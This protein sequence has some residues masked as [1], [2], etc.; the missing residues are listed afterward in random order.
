MKVKL[1]RISSVPMF[2]FIHIVE[3]LQHYAD[4][5]NIHTICIKSQGPSPQV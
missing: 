2:S 1:C 3:D 4:W 5:Q